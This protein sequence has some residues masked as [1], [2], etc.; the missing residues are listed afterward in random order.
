MRNAA[1]ARRTVFVAR[2]QFLERIKARV[3][4]VSA[5][6]GRPLT[7]VLASPDKPFGLPPWKWRV[8]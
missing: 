2:K 1:Q 5:A 6:L 4:V 8:C 7:C 3:E